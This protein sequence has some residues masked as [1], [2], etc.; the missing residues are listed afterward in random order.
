MQAGKQPWQGR[1]P[2][3][4]PQKTNAR[5]VAKR[6]QRR[7]N[8]KAVGAK[9]AAVAAKIEASR[10]AAIA[11]KEAKAQKKRKNPMDCS[12]PEEL[13][14]AHDDERDE[15]GGKKPRV[16]E[17]PAKEQGDNKKKRKNVAELLKG[18]R[19]AVK[20][21]Q[22]ETAGKWKVHLANRA[23]KTPVAAKPEEVAEAAKASTGA[24]F[25]LIHL[26]HKKAAANGEIIF[27]WNCGYYMINK[28]QNLRNSCAIEPPH[29]H[30]RSMRDKL[31][32]GFYPQKIHGK[33]KR[34]KD[35]TSTDVSVPVVR[36]DPP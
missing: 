7:K 24:G 19:K 15:H 5:L 34:W 35:G 30:A 8:A 28:S 23:T 22:E 6:P 1:K 14:E 3:R 21:A 36:L 26:S 18:I 17:D 13:P 10:L 16:G 12:D 32:Q 20:V 9:E 4:R 11:R 31:R 33:I 2:R 27:C 25:D 29:N